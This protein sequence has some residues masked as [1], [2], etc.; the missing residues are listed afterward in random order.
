MT[1]LLPSFRCDTKH[2]ILATVGI[3]S[4]WAYHI[5]FTDVQCAFFFITKFISDKL[6]KHFEKVFYPLSAL[7]KSLEMFFRQYGIF[8]LTNVSISFLFVKFSSIWYSTTQISCSIIMSVV[9][10]YVSYNFMEYP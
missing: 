6:S 3:N 1:P 5:R 2:I 7:L 8:L 4:I 9:G 10:F